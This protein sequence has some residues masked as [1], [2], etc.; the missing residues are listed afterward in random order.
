MK[1]LNKSQYKVINPMD[2]KSVVCDKPEG[3]CWELLK[4]KECQRLKRARGY[5]VIREHE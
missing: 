4:Q 2:E 5:I 3:K 1:Q